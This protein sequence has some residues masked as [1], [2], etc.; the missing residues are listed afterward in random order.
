MTYHYR[1]FGLA[2]ASDL[3]C[4]ELIA[5]PADE[6]V[7]IH[8]TLETVPETIDAPLHVNRRVQV[9]QGVY[10][11]RVD[12]IARYRIE[13]GRTIRVEPY[14]GADAGDVRLFLLGTA[15][16][17][18]LHQQGRLPLH[19]C[20][21]AVD[22]GAHAFCGE[23]G[24]GKS[25]LAAAFHQRGLPVLCD[26]VGLA[27]PGPDGAALFYP[28]FPRIK[29]WQ[30]ALDH[31]DIDNVPLIRDQTRADK[32]HLMLRDTF[33]G[34][35]L[36]FRRLYELARGDAETEARIE[37]LAHHDTIGLLIQ[38]TYRPGMV[39]RIGDPLAHLRQCGHVAGAIRGFRYTRPWNLARIDASLDRLLDHLSTGIE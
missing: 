33:H 16:G 15:I 10:Q 37:A 20:A 4:P 5:A 7:D 12:D 32:Y 38:N 23:S 29:L 6:N 26:D 9:G 18:L 2:V 28:G 31:F 22:G 36:P 17:A 30:D 1:L 34:A 13:Q 11:F 3:E 14:P 35:P 25:T 24:A 19:V 27:V 21:V 8:I 39:R